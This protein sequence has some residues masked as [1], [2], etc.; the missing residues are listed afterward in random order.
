[1]N[2]KI[3]SF[4]VGGLLFNETIAVIDYLIEGKIKE[5]NKVIKTTEV[6]K[7]NSEASRLRI[8][9]EIRRRD[10]AVNT[11]VWHLIGNS[12]KNEQQ[13][14]LFYVCLKASKL[15]FDFQVEVVLEKWRSLDHIVNKN[16]AL[17]FIDKKSVNYPEIE[18]WTDNTKEK[19]ATV[20]IRILNE[21]G[22]LKKNRLV[23][24]YVSDHF[25]AFFIKQGD[26]WFLELCLMP[27]NQRD[28]IND[29]LKS[30]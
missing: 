27:K 9:S 29:N 30:F 10:K 19:T 21:S 13:L 4:S 2:K 12:V 8:L 26:P 22:I 5:L 6:I 17:Y 1:M 28:K 20:L 14:A 25:W 18:K 11:E 16:D 3:T 24:P 15:L 23:Q 7:T